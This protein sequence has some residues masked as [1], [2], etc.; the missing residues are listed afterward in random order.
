VRTVNEA[1]MKPREATAA[2]AAWGGLGA[3][4][5]GGGG[6]VLPLQCN[7]CRRLV[8]SVV[9]VPGAIPQ[10]I[11]I[12]CG[13]CEQFAC[14]GCAVKCA[15]C[16]GDACRFCSTVSYAGKFE[17]ILCGPCHDEQGVFRQPLGHSSG[18]AAG[19]GRAEMGDL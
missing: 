11:G 7:V 10:R 13:Y 19:G 15:Q 16:E 14:L 1:L 8:P 18:Q 12:K 4:N 2:A 6:G 9:A 5:G 3:E 17:A